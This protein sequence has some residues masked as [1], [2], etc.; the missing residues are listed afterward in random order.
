ML[1]LY[2][3]E[4]DREMASV[5]QTVIPVRGVVGLLV[6]GQSDSLLPRVD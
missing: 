4:K 6:M 3:E 1:L 2:F 5:G